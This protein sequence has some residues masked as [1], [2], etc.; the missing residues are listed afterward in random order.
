[1]KSE[2][3]ILVSKQKEILSFR[4]LAEGTITTY[5]S[6]LTQFIEWVETELSDKA[7][8]DVSYPEIR[9]LS[10]YGTEDRQSNDQRS[11]CSASPSISLCSEAR[12][13]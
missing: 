6:Y 11:H 12:L 13:G 7:L 2:N 5:I 3:E 9:R 10:P 1:M 8:R 4:D